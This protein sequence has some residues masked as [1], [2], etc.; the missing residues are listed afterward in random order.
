MKKILSLLLLATAAAQGAE[1]L[2]FSGSNPGGGAKGIYAYRFNTTSGEL[3]PEG[4]AV[5]TTNPSFLTVSASG[6]FLY[7][8]NEVGGKGMVSA[9]SIDRTA[10]RLTLINQ[11]SSKGGGPCHLALDATGR[12]LA[13]ANYGTGSV[14]VLPV[15][16]DGRLGEAVAFDQHHGSGV[17]HARQEGPHAHEAVFSP[18]NRYLL[19][20]DLGL[21]QILVYRFDAGKG[22]IAPN[23]PPFAVVAPGSGPRHL[24]FHPNGKVVYVI[25]ELASTVIA[26]HYDAA[27]GALQDFQTL[28][29]LPEHFTQPSTAAEIAVNAAGSAVYASNRGHDSI[30]LFDIQPELFKLAE[31]EHTPT[32]GKTPRHFTLDPDGR[33]LLVSNQDS[34]NIEVFRVH[35]RSGELTPTRFRPAEQPRPVCLVFV[36]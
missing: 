26:F 27:K 14:A 6:Q 11:V 15:S 32:L 7:A 2:A 4:L 22:T 23:A 3:K 35:Q 21:D 25:N 34:D 17:N 5:E 12:W 13:V 9:F 24:A 20:P 19:V 18:D 28:S 16:A 10:A 30:A 31:P 29:T 33:F 1:L 8:V 36:K